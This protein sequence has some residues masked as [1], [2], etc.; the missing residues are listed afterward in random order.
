MAKKLL[1][2][3]SFK[4]IGWILLIPSCILTVLSSVGVTMPEMNGKAF[5]ISN[6][7]VLG[8]KVFLGFVELNLFPTIIG[9]VFS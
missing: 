1:F 5:A 8:D 7:Q 2:P 4:I 3:N 6:N 9:I